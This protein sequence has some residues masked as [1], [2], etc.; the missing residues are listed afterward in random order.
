MESKLKREVHAQLFSFF[1]FL[2]IMKQNDLIRELEK[3]S[4]T[5]E[6]I[7]NWGWSLI[8]E[9]RH[10]VSYSLLHKEKKKISFVT[11][12]GFP[13]TQHC[14]FTVDK[15]FVYSRSCFI[16]CSELR[17]KK[18]TLITHIHVPATWHRPSVFLLVRPIPK[19]S[20]FWG[21]YAIFF[22]VKTSRICTIVALLNSQRQICTPP[23]FNYI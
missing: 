21:R 7:V 20:V 8:I 23:L 1:S 3:P 2:L 22:N 18:Q 6:A 5:T 11:V 9:I 19:T 17:A 10:P 14:K 12:I 4:K 13:I 16:L 15:N